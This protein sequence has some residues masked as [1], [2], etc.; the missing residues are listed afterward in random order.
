MVRDVVKPSI[1]EK[2]L[3]A[4]TKSTGVILFTLPRTKTATL[5]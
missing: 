3:R 4:V 1:N 2:N 5:C